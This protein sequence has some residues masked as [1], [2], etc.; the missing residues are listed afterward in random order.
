MYIVQFNEQVNYVAIVERFIYI[1]PRSI[2]LTDG[3]VAGIFA[4]SFGHIWSQ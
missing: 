1:F 4:H 3:Y 2:L